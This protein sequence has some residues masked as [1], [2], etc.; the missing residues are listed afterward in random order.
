MRIHFEKMV[1]RMFHR[2][3]RPPDSILLQDVF[4]IGLHVVYVYELLH[5]FFSVDTNVGV[6]EDF[7]LGHYQDEVTAPHIIVEHFAA[8]HLGGLAQEFDRAIRKSIGGKFGAQERLTADKLWFGQ[9]QNRRHHDQRWQGAGP[10]QLVDRD[11]I[12]GDAP[13]SSNESRR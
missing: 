6:D 2:Q 4:P 12:R 11:Q 8:Y 1:Q 5:E 13:V 9:D 3:N 10:S 7:L